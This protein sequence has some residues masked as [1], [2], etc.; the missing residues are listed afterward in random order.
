M[1]GSDVVIVVMSDS[2]SSGDEK[3]TDFFNFTAQDWTD[4]LEENTERE[5][6]DLQHSQKIR[7][8]AHVLAGTALGPQR[9]QLD[10]VPRKRFKSQTE[11]EEIA[12]SSR[13]NEDNSGQ[14]VT[15]KRDNGRISESI[16][17]D[18]SILD[19]GEPSDTRCKSDHV[20]IP[21]RCYS[22]VI[23]H[24]KPVT[25]TVWST[26]GCDHLLLTSSLDGRIKL[27]HG[28]SRRCVFVREAPAG[29]RCAR[30]SNCGRRIF[31]CGFDKKLVLIDPTTD[32]TLY[33]ADFQE[34]PS[35]LSVAPES[36]A[37]VFVGSTNGVTLWDTRQESHAAVR[38]YQS[39]C[40]QVLDVLLINEGR[41]LVF[42]GD[43]VAR[44][45]CHTALMV[46]DVTS[47]ALLSNQVYQE[48]YSCPSLQLLSAA[49]FAAQTNG[50]YIAI[51]N[52]VRPY[53]MNKKKRF[54]GHKVAGYSVR[55]SVSVDG[56]L[57][58]S[59]DAE[60][61]LHF[62]WTNSCALAGVLQLEGISAATHPAWYPQGG[63][64]VA[65]GCW[66]G[67]LHFCQ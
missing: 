28:L 58:C 19:C 66:D 38:S 42:S 65:V 2:D 62:Y 24:K 25:S 10:E 34:A 35:C 5:F 27:W 61:L 14:R 23:A 53:K 60:G 13:V 3:C 67:S 45:S 1:V 39:H 55:L 29:V 40:G 46:W 37:L 6:L 18:P 30:F 44:D 59:G 15:L 9:P 49:H 11:R 51:F 32:A 16:L 54:E 8:T 63:S 33:S 57:L 64:D 20:R 36:E 50:N 48:R 7:E 31:R 43:L 17:L 12:A 4:E 26:S 22:S 52:T 41:E 56:S 47:G 21:K